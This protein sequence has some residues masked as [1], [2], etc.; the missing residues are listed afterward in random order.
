M[1]N[2]NKAEEASM[3]A[4]VMTFADLMSLLMCF[5]VLLLSFSEV[6]LK[7]FKQV[8][9]SMERAFGVQREVKAKE[10]PRGTSI[11]AQ[12]FS[13]GKPEPTILN[14]VRQ[15]T[16]SEYSD[17]LKIEQEAKKSQDS[18]AAATQQTA[19][20]IAEEMI[21]EIRSGE[22]EV[23]SKE[24]Q[25]VIRI[26]E[27]GS[28]NSGSA[29]L[30]KD[31]LPTIKKIGKVLANIP[32]QINVS[33]Y[34]DNIP[35]NTDLF[36]SN[37]EL[38]AIRAFAVIHELTNNK[39][40]NYKRFILTGYGENNPMAPNDTEVNRSKNRRVELLVN[41]NEEYLDLPDEIQSYVDGDEAVISLDQVDFGPDVESTFP[42]ET[43]EMVDPNFVDGGGLGVYD[44]SE[45]YDYE[46]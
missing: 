16:T 15:S 28:F 33:G 30:K 4:W 34:T 3:P 13:P 9:G 12:E 25:I 20:Q 24:Q 2:I 32:G 36:R 38:S 5:F 42:G 21:E 26:L 1:E 43:Y 6:D 29:I 40:L 46:I 8:A 14:E 45:V 7:K 18:Q 11:V 10:T 23:E 27:K 44:E 31:F 35:I 37:W 22:V 19:L 39:F 17:K 41:Q